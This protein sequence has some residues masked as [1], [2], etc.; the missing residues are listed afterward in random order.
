MSLT[1]PRRIT[2]GHAH[3]VALG[4][5]EA[6]LDLLRDLA[7]EDWHRPT[8]CTGW[9]VRDIVAHVAGAMEE[10]ARLH[11][12]LRHYA[13]A[14]RRHPEMSPL[15]AVN[16]VQIE[17]RAGTSPVDLVAE[18]ERL[19]P[20]AARARRRMPGLLRRTPVPG[21]D[22]G[23]PP[24]SRFGYL[25]DV[26]YPRDLWMHRVDVERATG[27]R[28][29]PSTSEQEVLEQVVLDLGEAWTGPTTDLRLTGVGAWRL[30]NGEPTAILETEPVEVCRMLSGRPADP[31]VSHTGDP[32]AV[33]VFRA[34]RIAF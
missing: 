9:S 21:K 8:D 33:D 24:G 18:L 17:E 16:Q 1:M 29:R 31:P 5:L 28:H 10:G 19:G 4:E 14:P 20:R 3:D 26:I 6:F 11:V 2:P 7:A 27:R 30:G 34:A 12:Q 22:N 32:R 25:V 13:L 23:L 15:D